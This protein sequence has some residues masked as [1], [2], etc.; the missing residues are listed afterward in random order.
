MDHLVVL[1][2][3]ELMSIWIGPGGAIEGLPL[4][5]PPLLPLDEK[6]AKSSRE[7]Q[8]KTGYFSRTGKRGSGRG[9]S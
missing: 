7:F 3:R 4:P 5:D 1:V 2:G 8:W 6:P 9:E